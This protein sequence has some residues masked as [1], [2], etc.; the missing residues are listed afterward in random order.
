MLLRLAA[1]FF[2]VLGLSGCFTAQVSLDYLPRPGMHVM[3]RPEVGVGQF[4]DNRGVSSY[5]LGTS[6]NAI[7]TPTEYVMLRVPADEAVRNAFLHALEARTMLADGAGQ[8]YYLSGE[9]EVL[10]SSIIKKP[11]AEV[12]L[13]VHLLAAGSER[14]VFRRTY[15][16]QRAAPGFAFG[17]QDTVQV[18]REL[19]SRALQDAVDKALDDPALRRAMRSRRG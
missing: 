11:F 9:I 8:K 14:I 6:R 19:A 4:Y 1:I 15:S 13:R 2:A 3:G 18:M 12:V 10:R 7:G 16:S 5:Y 17:Y